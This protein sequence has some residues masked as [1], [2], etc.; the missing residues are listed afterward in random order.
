MLSHDAGFVASDVSQRG[1]EEVDV[2]Q[3]ELRYCCDC[4]ML[5]D[6]GGVEE[7]VLSVRTQCRTHAW[8]EAHLPA[9]KR[10]ADEKIDALTSGVVY[11]D[12]SH[13]LSH[14]RTITSYRGPIHCLDDLGERFGK[15]F[16]GYRRPVDLDPFGTRQKVR[17][18][19]RADPH[20]NALSLIVSLQKCRDEAASGPFSLCACYMDHVETAQIF[21]LSRGEL[22]VSSDGDGSLNALC[23]PVA[24][25]YS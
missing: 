2:V 12:E 5:E 25:A 4:W 9:T 19:E 21:L 8:A 20:R 18:R 15:R 14:S 23:S 6:I 13:E 16:L 1:S 24:R 11:G 10:L 7:A 3:P 17:S 22:G